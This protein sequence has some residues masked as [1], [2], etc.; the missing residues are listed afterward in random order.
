MVESV[1]CEQR[2]LLLKQIAVG[3]M[4]NFSY[5]IADQKT[6]RALVLDPA[7]AADKI[8]AEVESGGFKLT[9]VIATHSHYDHVNAVPEILEKFDIPVYVNKNELAVAKLGLDI[10]VDLRGGA[11]LVTDEETLELGE[12]TIRFIHTP[13]H[14][15]GSQCVIAGENLLTGDTLFIGGCGRY[16]LPGGD[17]GALK[18]S[19][20]RIAGLPG[21]LVIYPGHDYGD[22]PFRKLADEKKDNPFL[23]F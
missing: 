4:Q 23:K 6:K 22:V 16:D 5:L 20:K 15:P 3:S 19:L 9:G 11:K 18:A 17:E 2:H 1:K 13:G 10:F 21:E 14:T 7:W 8:L 12:T